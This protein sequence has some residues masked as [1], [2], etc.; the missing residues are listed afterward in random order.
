MTSLDTAATR[1]LLDAGHVPGAVLGA[2]MEGTVVDLGGDRVAKA[3]HG[4]GVADL[5][6]LQTF[7]RA[8]RAG[9][10]TLATPLVEDVLPVGDGSE[11]GV[12]VEARLG[13]RPLRADMGEGERHVGDPEIAAVLDV[14]RALA[15]V[16]PH[17]DLGVLPVLDGEPPFDAR[18]P[19]GV[20]LGGLVERRLRASGHV[21]RRRVPDVDRVARAVVER[22]HAIE[23]GPTAVVHGDL[24]PG[25][26]LVTGDVASGV[27]DFGFLTTLGD[28]RFDAA[29]AASVH[30]MYGVRARDTEAAIDAALVSE[31]GHD[32]EVLHLYRAAYA[33]VTCT[34]YS[35]SGSDG[36][37][38]WCARML[39]RDDVRRA[40]H[41]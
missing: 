41:D 2:G 8:L 36:H 33:L 25:N 16:T 39:D 32:P 11:R 9:G 34:S 27:L 5:R 29:V 40:V 37:F 13:G 17:P 23:P 6:R 18:V 30:D 4:R 19:F 22:L 15:A 38:A 3:W 20:S 7:H 31:L 10:M 1:A 28:P 24:I 21:L 35:A 14:L 26:I 12:T